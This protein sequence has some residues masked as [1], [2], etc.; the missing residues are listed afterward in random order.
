MLAS[1]RGA[2]FLSALCAAAGCAPSGQYLKPGFVPPARIAVLLLN[3]HSNDLDG[4][5]VVRYWLDRRLTE[6]KGYV[7][8]PLARV[9]EAL[10]GLGIH[11]GGQLPGVT[12]QTL[13]KLLGADALLYGDLL[14]FGAKTAGFLNARE[15]RAQ[16]R[17]IDARTGEKL[18][19]SRG[20]G[21]SSSTAA[22]VSGAIQAGVQ[23]VG[24]LIGEKAAH[25]PYKNETLDMVWNAIQ[26][27]PR[28]PR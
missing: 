21:G 14:A 7:T 2:L 6:K 12:P 10:H 5:A 16:L 9:D 28:K 27:L 23:H 1:G 3:N 25:S 4:P 26:Y 13:G 18:W 15:V 22:S 20:S 11:D 24:T 19:E 8:I 17:L